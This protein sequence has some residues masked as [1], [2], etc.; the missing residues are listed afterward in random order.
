MIADA[1]KSYA[2]ARAV[3]VGAHDAEAI[4]GLEFGANH[5]CHQRRLVA[6]HKILRNVNIESDE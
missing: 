4:P 2:K 3:G 6:C 1:C 5:K